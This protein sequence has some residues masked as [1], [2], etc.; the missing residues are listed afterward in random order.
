MKRKLFLFPLVI[1][2]SGCFTPLIFPSG[3]IE[4]EE[5]IAAT[6][7]PYP[8][9]P[10]V[11]FYNGEVLTMED[12]S[13]MPTHQAIAI[14]HARI[15]AVGSDADILD[16]R[17]STTVVIDLGG[18]TLMPGFVEGHSH[19]LH[20]AYRHSLD[21]KQ[22]AYVALRYGITTLNEMLV[23]QADID[24]LLWAEENEI[25]PLRVNAFLAYNS[26]YL[27]RPAEIEETA[28]ECPEWSLDIDP[29]LDARRRL[30]I[31]GIK[32]FID[33]IGS[34]G[35]GCPALTDPY[36]EEFQA[37]DDFT[38][39]YNENG[40]LYLSQFET[41]C[42]VAE[43][44][45]R[46]YR[47][48]FH[49]M[50]DR[51]IDVALTAIENALAGESNARYRH[52]IHHNSLLRDDQMERYASSYILASVRAYFDTCDQDNYPNL[53]YGP[54]RAPW[55]GNRYALL[56]KEIRAFSEGDFAWGSEPG[57][58]T[59]S[60]QLNPLVNLYGLVTRK[61]SCYV[62]G[63]PNFTAEPAPWLHPDAISVEEALRMLTI[64]AAYSVSLEHAI[65]TLEVGKFAD[66]II[67]SGNPLTIDPDNILNLEVWMTMVD[68]KRVYCASG[69]ED[70]CP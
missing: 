9:N 48:A 49:A 41:N 10:T 64:D 52:A 65:G 66:L 38:N 23:D 59:R 35:R 63:R 69:H 25:L 2:L 44:Q 5:L 47:V 34:S 28:A 62:E 61:K 6:P 36:P 51:G 27:D 4:D 39:C 24:W 56:D 57:D 54:D 8:V 43:A 40:D 60:N 21:R 17:R 13:P 1:F 32:I 19:V 15:V 31:P 33:G 14:Q 7:I 29:I 53:Y 45:A 12:I 18:R 67:L 70:I 68:G 26:P 3:P 22:A 42:I 16:L 11:I 30:R 20:F 37:T 50:G 55:A 46:G 58:L